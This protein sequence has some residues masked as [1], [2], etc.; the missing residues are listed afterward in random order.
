MT[1][2]TKIAK[3]LLNIKAVGFSLQEP[4]TFK[5]G[6]KSPVYVDNRRLPYHP[7]EWRVVIESFV[8][9]IKIKNLEFDCIAGIEAAGIPHSAALGFYL[10][11]P[12]VFVRKTVKDHGTKKMV[13]GGDVTGKRVLLIED[14]VTTGGSSLSGVVSLRQAG[15]VVKQCLAITSYEMKEATRMFTDADVELHTLT[16]FSD[17]F[18]QAEKEQTLTAA[19]KK[20][21]TKWLTNPQGWGV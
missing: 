21:V 1:S 4:I 14:H 11:L 20:I 2:R 15:A 17:I 6:I 9:L 10:S 13:E 18:D 8:E 5:S 3:A 12:S 19:E 16:T 7:A